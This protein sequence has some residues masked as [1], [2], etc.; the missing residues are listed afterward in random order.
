MIRLVVFQMLALEL[1]LLKLELPLA[2]E[3]LKENRRIIQ[4][5]QDVLTALAECLSAL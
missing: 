5:G 4:P 1:V 3:P 2:F